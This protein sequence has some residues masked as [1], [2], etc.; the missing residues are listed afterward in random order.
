MGRARTSVCIVTGTRAEFGLLRPVMDAVAAHERLELR[1]VVTGAHLLGPAETWRE[2]AASYA[3]DARV[4]MQRPGES[5]RMADARALGRGVEGLAGAFDRV[6]ADWV[7]VLGDRIEAL[8]GACAASVGGVAL[9]HIHGGDR[10]EGVADEAMRHA[11]TK[12]AHLHLAATEQSA[13]R[14]IRMGEASE[15]VVVTGSPAIDG[16]D[17][18]RAMSGVDAEQ[19]MGGTPSVLVMLHPCGLSGDGERAWAD[20]VIGGVAD[21]VRGGHVAVMAPNHDAGRESLLC[22]MESAVGE[23][24]WRWI[25]HLPRERFVGLLKSMRERGGVLVGNSSAGLIECAAL[26]VGVVNVGPRQNGRERGG[27]VVDV[28]SADRAAVAEAIGRARGLHLSGH[29]HPYGDGDAGKR[30]A[31]AIAGVDI[32]SAGFLRKCNSY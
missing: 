29:A 5:G 2:V 18:M 20:A 1:V 31:G 10:A 21:A 26:G 19:Q 25:E 12:L 13:A 27:N 28:A 24:G 16:L 30:I 32:G 14:I 4:P 3:I 17:Q 23:R 22:V 11:I 8:A 15:R 6:R 7:V 9:A